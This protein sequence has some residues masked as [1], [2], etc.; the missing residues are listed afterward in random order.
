MTAFFNGKKIDLRALSE[1]DV[2]V[3]YQWF[4]DPEVTR[5]MNKGWSSNTEQAQREFLHRLSRSEEDLQWGVVFHATGELIGTVGLHKMSR[6]HRHASVSILIGNKK[7]WGQGLAGEAVGLVTR[8]SFTGLDMH[9]LFTGIWADNTG[10]LK[11]FEK[12]GYVVEG[13]ICEKYFKDGIY[14]DEIILGLTHAQWQNKN[15]ALS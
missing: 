2:P 3:W 6:I 11:A 7:Y 5:L 9:K 12:N 14:H 8:Y 15:D 4:N 1:A 10:S 13:R